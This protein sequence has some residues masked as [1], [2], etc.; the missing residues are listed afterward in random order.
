MTGSST[1]NPVSSSAGGG[2]SSTLPP[3]HPSAFNQG[4]FPGQ[5]RATTLDRRKLPPT[6]I[7]HVFSSTNTR[8]GSL[9]P[10]DKEPLAN[11]LQSMRDLRGAESDSGTKRAKHSKGPLYPMSSTDPS[12]GLSDSSLEV[13]YPL[14]TTL[15][16]EE[17]VQPFHWKAPG[18]DLKIYSA[19][20]GDEKNGRAFAKVLS[21]PK[22]V[23]LN[24]A[25]PLLSRVFSSTSASTERR[26]SNESFQED[27]QQAEGGEFASKIIKQPSRRFSRPSPMSSKILGG[28]SN[29]ARHSFTKKEI[30][31]KEDNRMPLPGRRR[32]SME[33]D[34]QQQSSSSWKHSGSEPRRKSSFEDRSHSGG[35]IGRI[36]ETANENH[37]SE[38]SDSEGTKQK[39]QQTATTTAFL[40]SFASKRTQQQQPSALKSPKTHSLPN[41]VKSVAI[42]KRLTDPAVLARVTQ[43]NSDFT[44]LQTLTEEQTE[45][46][47]GSR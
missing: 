7:S 27:E 40:Q 14:T 30:S 32:T 42:P 31:F 20:M 35:S 10:V 9:P 47:N 34:Q 29:F 4:N 44:L 23:H 8:A 5:P 45:H 19:T 37:V 17:R 13:L 43:V 33:N 12:S 18:P 11:P 22:V 36:E 28:E 3:L 46:Y 26:E 21:P 25:N 6:D 16:H 38:E 41:S 1:E 2:Q 24:E 15:P 39:Q